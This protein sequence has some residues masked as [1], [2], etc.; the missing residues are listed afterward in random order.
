MTKIAFVGDLHG[1][2]DLMLEKTIDADIIIQ[3]GDFGTFIDESRMDRATRKHEGI[4][5][6]IDY[7]DGKK[8]F[9]KPV[10]FIHGNHDDF[11]VIDEIKYDPVDNLTYL[12]NGKVYE[13]AGFRIGAVGGNYSEV[14][15]PLPK[16][17]P[18]L[19]GKRR[20]HFNH[21]DI[22]SFLGQYRI[23]IFVTHDAPRE[24]GLIG[25]NKQPAGSPFLDTLIY[26]HMPDFYFHGHYHRFNTKQI[27]STKLIGLDKIDGKQQS[28]YILEGKK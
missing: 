11:D 3:L 15:F 8:K 28:V 22:S 16:E 6:F 21:Q 7:F 18:K 19:Q 10:Y 12:E 9:P 14:R 26:R 4:G 2:I 25:R 27:G 13:I 20:K 5:D 1:K 24:A 17:H 23:D